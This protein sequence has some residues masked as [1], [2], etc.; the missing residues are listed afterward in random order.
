MVLETEGKDLEEIQDRYEAAVFQQIQIFLKD[1]IIPSLAVSRLQKMKNLSEAYLFFV[2]RK[3]ESENTIPDLISLNSINDWKEFW[4][5][6]ELNKAIFRKGIVQS[7][8]YSE[9][10]SSVSGLIKN[11]SEYAKI[12]TD[13]L[14]DIPVS[15]E[16]KL[17]EA[18]QV[19]EIIKECESLRDRSLIDFSL[20][21]LKKISDKNV[22]FNL[23][24]EVNRLRKLLKHG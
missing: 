14:K 24:K 20:E 5:T 16:V 13:V 10:E 12:L 15:E 3:A 18:V 11:E 22:T 9:L 6:Y 8:N 21:S 1:P 19:I 2:P 7:Y 17:S 23:S 4:N